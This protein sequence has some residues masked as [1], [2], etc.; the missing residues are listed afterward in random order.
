MWFVVV[1]MVDCWMFA[2]TD[3]CCILLWLLMLQMLLMLLLMLLLC[4]WV[5]FVC[6]A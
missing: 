2:V 3:G 1:A 4:S 6:D 5:F